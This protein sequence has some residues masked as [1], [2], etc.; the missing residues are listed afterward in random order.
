ML[1]AVLNRRT[2]H[3]LVLCTAKASE[4]AY[5]SCHAILRVVVSYILLRLHIYGGPWFD[6]KA[7]HCWRLACCSM[8]FE[9]PPHLEQN[10]DSFGL[11]LMFMSMRLAC[12]SG[13]RVDP[14]S[15]VGV[16]T[17]M[18]GGFLRFVLRFWCRSEVG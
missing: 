12:S 17:G 10:T 9:P 18:I 7:C 15:A 16:A 14:V 1:N 11:H 3:F 4:R 8:V 6:D 2:A 5:G 13:L